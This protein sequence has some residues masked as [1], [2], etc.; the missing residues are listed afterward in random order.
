V[1]SR[2]AGRGCRLLE[3][4]FV[5]LAACLAAAAPAEPSEETLQ[6]VQRSLAEEN[7]PAA[8]ARLEQEAVAHPEDCA[9]RAWLAWFEIETGRGDPAEPL[10]AAGG[11]PIRPEDR[12]RWTLLRALGAERRD[13][14]G[15][16]Q[17]ALSEV[18]ERQPLW[19]EDRALVRTLSGRHLEGYTLP[20][21]AL[22]E[23]ALGATSNAFAMSPT[24]AAR[25]EAPGSGVARPDL[26]LALRAP[27]GAVTPSLELGAR[28]YGIASA[29]AREVSH[30]NLSVAGAL[31]F[32][33]GALLPTVR[34][35]HDE[36]LLDS[37]GGR[38]S[39]AD[40]AEV[41]LSPSR[42]VTLYGG[43]GHRV[44]F[45]DDWRTRTEWNLAGMG[46]TSLLGRPVIF[47][48]AF[49]YYGANRDVH[50]QVGGTLTAAAEIPLRGSLRARLAASG[51]VDDFQHS[52]GPDG[53]I[54]FGTT[55]RRRDATL[56]LSAGLW[57]SLGARAALGLT[58]ELARRW[59]T[60]DNAALRYYPYV[61]H[62]V[63]VSLRVGDGGN[64]WRA[65]NAEDP[66]HVA[67]PYRDLAERSVLWDDHMRRLLRQEEDLAAD[68]GCLVP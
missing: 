3:A 58:Y 21:E 63:L 38:Y 13:D 5:V 55:E 62:R 36:L 43:V 30:A 49:R 56:R 50:D 57:R 34:Y 45:T 22:A 39:A 10:L 17:N 46:A 33:R 18:G 7:W 31:R 1:S 65:R 51:A 27:E 52:G 40:E 48:G 23:I 42:G 66:D 47:G 68:C 2:A 28:G 15:G 29:E 14:A 44:F 16:V 19:P 60:A 54:A 8:R 35:R 11:C 37:A 24:D 61:D 32:G 64:P 6:V 26:R 67:L 59:S 4:A 25:R 9:V 12:G 41:E 53:L 20:L